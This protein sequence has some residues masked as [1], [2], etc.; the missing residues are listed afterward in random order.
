M[1]PG[2]FSITFQVKDFYGTNLFSA[3]PGIARQIVSAVNCHIPMLGNHVVAMDALRTLR[4]QISAMPRSAARSR[5]LDLI[6][7][8]LRPHRGCVMTRGERFWLA[9]IFTLVIVAT[10]AFIQI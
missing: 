9:A 2:Q 8:A 6:E 5:A 4:I 1:A 10:M 3:A 7:D